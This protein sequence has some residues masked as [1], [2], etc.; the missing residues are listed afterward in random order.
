VCCPSHWTTSSL[1]AEMLCYTSVGGSAMVK[2]RQIDTTHSQ[3]SSTT[4]S[5]LVFT[6]AGVVIHDAAAET[7]SSTTKGSSTSGAITA[8]AGRG[9]A[10]SASPAKSDSTKLNLGHRGLRRAIALI[11][12][13]CFVY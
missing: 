1:N 10:A 11:A 6:F 12:A 9:S 5:D 3:Y 2:E 13:L 7:G 4:V 8:S